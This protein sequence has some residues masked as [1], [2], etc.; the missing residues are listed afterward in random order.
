MKL[1]PRPIA[2]MVFAACV[3]SCGGDEPEQRYDHGFVLDMSDLDLGD[4]AVDLVGETVEDSGGTE[5]DVETD[6]VVDSSE[7]PEE[8]PGS[9]VED[10][11][12]GDT[13]AVEYP[14]GDWGPYFVGTRSFTWLDVSRWRFITTRVWYPADVGPAGPGRVSYL[15]LIAGNS[16]ENADSDLSGAPYPVVLFSHGNK[17]INFQSFSFTEKLA[18]HG[19]VVLSPD[20]A[21][22]T[23]IDNPS[24]E[25]VGQIA[26]DRPLDIAYVYMKLVE[27]NFASESPLFGLADT[28]EVAVVGHSFGGYT[29][30]LLAGGTVDRDAAVARCDAGVEGD[31]FCP[32][33]G[34]WPEGSTGARPAEM[35]ILSAAVAFAPG[36][37]AAFGDEG[38]V[39][40]DMPLL[41][42][43]GTLDEYTRADL[44]PT[45]LGAPAPKLKIEIENMGHMGFTDICRIPIANL[46]PD[47]AVMCDP[48]VFIDIDRGFEII[49][50]FTIAF[51]RLHLK[52][53]TAMAGYLTAEFA[54]T[55]PEVGYASEE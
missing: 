30:L 36:G 31:V 9:D 20:H 35:S 11:A 23:M 55:F 46:V 41:L 18:S 53:E 32:Y 24:D 3:S 48:E 42:M 45:Y 33:I 54:A 44:Q 2:L 34:Y 28:G 39:D 22:N 10:Q 47:L 15:G 4:L 38:L 52:G 29:A 40:I 1:L 27:E 25:Q 49:N 7:L 12:E 37:Y 19:F 16:F 6:L 21:G 43:G 51:L 13:A 17:G 50:P 8:P 26:L 14:P 5:Q